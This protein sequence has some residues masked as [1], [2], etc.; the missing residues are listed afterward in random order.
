MERSQGPLRV[1]LVEDSA[2][3]RNLLSELAAAAC[4]TIVGYAENALSAIKEIESLEIDVIVV[5]ISLQEGS[6]FDVLRATHSPRSGKGPKRIVLSN[7]SSP[8]YRKAAARLDVDR[9]FDKSTDIVKM[10]EYLT[11]L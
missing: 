1:Y 6:G 2:I 3:I 8:E 7:Y 5:D 10:I 11:Q 4:V 9:Y